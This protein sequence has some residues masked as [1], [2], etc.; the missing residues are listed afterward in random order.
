MMQPRTARSARVAALNLDTTR[1]PEPPST[2]VSGT[3][4]KIIP[5]KSQNKPEKAQ[6]TVNK[7]DHGHRNIRITNELTDEHGDEVKLKKGAN[8]DV[9]VAAE[10]KG[11][12]DAANDDVQP[13]QHKVRGHDWRRRK[14]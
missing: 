2:T 11:S 9:T 13:T 6:I 10:P 1:N 8:V 14:S 7:S 5:A 12:P 4:D 3:V